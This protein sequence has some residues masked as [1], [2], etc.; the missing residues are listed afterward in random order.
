MP[1]PPPSSSPSFSP[2]EWTD[3][4]AL[5]PSTGQQLKKESTVEK[6]VIFSSHRNT[7]SN[8]HILALL[9]QT[10]IHAPLGAINLA[11][12]VESMMLPSHRDSHNLYSLHQAQQWK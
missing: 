1:T 2:N 4:Q 8:A 7:Y 5:A 12:V 11:E 10:R 6:W 3:R 9:T